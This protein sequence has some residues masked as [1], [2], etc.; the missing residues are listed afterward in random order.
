MANMYQ[1]ARERLSAGTNFMRKIT[2]QEW[3]RHAFCTVTELISLQHA[4][5]VPGPRYFKQVVKID[6]ALEHLLECLDKAY[7]KVKRHLVYGLSSTQTILHAL[8]RVGI[9]RTRP[10]G[11][12]IISRVI[13][14]QADDC[15]VRAAD[16]AE[17]SEDDDENTPP[18]H[19]IPSPV[20]L[21]LVGNPVV[22]EPH[23][24]HAVRT[25]SYLLG[26]SMA[27]WCGGISICCIGRG[28]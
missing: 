7:L 5:Y 19:G 2:H 20:S 11:R 15:T 27:V 9:I 6:F 24:A 22:V 13:S 4:I 26:I 3:H 16:H 8:R 28:R 21:R 23:A 25:V 12:R 14:D 18:Y 17:R 10:R 1:L